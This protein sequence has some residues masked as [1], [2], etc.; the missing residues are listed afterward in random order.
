MDDD[1]FRVVGV[2]G[3]RL[4]ILGQAAIR[5]AAIQSGV[6]TLM[7]MSAFD[8]AAISSVWVQLRLPVEQGG[9]GDWRTMSPVFEAAAII[10]QAQQEANV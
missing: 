2:R 5:R 9:T 1:I 10:R 7:A 4:V 8:V 6:E 3:G